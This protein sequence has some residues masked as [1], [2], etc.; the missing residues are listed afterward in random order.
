MHPILKKKFRISS[1]PPHHSQ[2]MHRPRFDYSR[3]NNGFCNIF[4]AK[5]NQESALG[6][7]VFEWSSVPKAPRGTF[8]WT[9]DN[10]RLSDITNY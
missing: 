8:L 6:T 1:Y 9:Y 5:S 7:S 10:D 3:Q 2:R 4:I